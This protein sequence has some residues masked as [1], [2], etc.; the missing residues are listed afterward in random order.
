M[1]KTSCSVEPAKKKEQT[2][3]KPVQAK[4][5]LEQDKEVNTIK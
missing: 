5:E 4:P 3:H 2:E 1:S